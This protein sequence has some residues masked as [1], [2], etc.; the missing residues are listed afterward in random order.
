MQRFIL[1][2]LLSILLQPVYSQEYKTPDYPKNFRPPLDLSPSS[3]GSFGELRSNHF[4]SG[5]DFRTNQREGYPVYAV[6]DGYV[7][8]LRVQVGGFGNA[9]YITHPNGYTT[10]YAHLQRFND[11]ISLTVNACQNSSESFDVDFPLIPIEIPVKKGD[12]IAW[13]GNTG[14]S[15]GPHLHF[16]VRDTNTE[17]T[18]NPQLFGFEIADRVKPSITGMYVYQL[19]DRQF[20]ENTPRQYFQVS[21]SSGN[22]QVIKDPLINVSDRVGFGIIT[23]DM[24]SASSNRNGVYSISLKLDDEIIYQAVWERFFFQHSRAINSHI[25]YPALLTGGRRIQKSFVEPGNPL[26]IYKK[27]INNGL[28]QLKDEQ[29]HRLQYTV[30]DARGNTSYLSFRI[31]YNPSVKMPVK[32]QPGIAVF[33]YNTVNEYSNEDIR[34]SVPSGTLYSDLNF[35]YSSSATPPGAYSKI[36]HVHTRLIPVHDGYTLSIKPA[37]AMPEYLR[38][39]AVIVNVQ[40]ASQGGEYK[41]G[42]ITTTARAFGSFYIAADTIAPVIRPVNISDGKSMAGTGR[43]VFKISDN[44]SGIRS[45]RA[46]LNGKWILMQYDL[47]TATLWYTFDD[48]AVPGR[49]KFLLEVTDMKLNTKSYS[50]TFTR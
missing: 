28:V 36:H 13:S 48:K 11:R 7:S 20:N 5:L 49:N 1:V 33:R 6:A 29:I 39:K 42:F 34:L 37:A 15:G 8:R 32:E 25:D 27:L 26:T 45:F 10:V 18:I 46:T 17:E 4:H 35:R 9:V 44:L 21:G 23:D 47:K 12:I 50:A 40:G 43:I 19:N 31:R 24:N 16:E 30:K 41:D 22:F 14:S 38:Q 2:F 3:A